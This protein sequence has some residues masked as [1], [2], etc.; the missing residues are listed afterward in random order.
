MPEQAEK[1]A[2]RHD[3]AV[4]ERRGRILEAAVMSFLENG[5]HQTGVRDIA[6]RAGVSLG[7]LYNHFPG[8]HDV[9]PSSSAEPRTA[10][11]DQTSIRGKPRF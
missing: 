3:R 9:P 6:R 7:N 10:A 2:T 8:E 11:F 4:A 1:P 5:Y